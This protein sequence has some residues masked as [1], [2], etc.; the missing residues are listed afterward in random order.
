MATRQ[1]LKDLADLRLREAEA[2]F[3][4]G[5]F[6]GAAYLAGYVVEVALKARICR[7]LDSPDYPD[8]GKLSRVY[9]VHDLDQLLLLS[10]LRRKLGLA[11][12]V[13]FKNWSTAVPWKPERRYAAAGSVTQRDAQEILDAVSESPGWSPKVDQEALVVQLRKVAKRIEKAAGPIALFMLLPPDSETHDA[14]NLVVSARGLDKK[15]IGEA[16]SQVTDWLR[17]DLEQAQWPLI[18]RATV[19]R[20]DDPFVKAINRVKSSVLGD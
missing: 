7:V 9:A 15:S 13:L 2:L 20:T 17:A 12:P 4:A 18:A 10:G 19:L 11:N 14:W 6:D 8:T 3:A 5:L 16:V 1:E